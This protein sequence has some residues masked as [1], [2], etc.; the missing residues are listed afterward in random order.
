HEFQT[1]L[2]SIKA[3]ASALLSDPPPGEPARGELVSIVDEETDRL[4]RLVT[5]AIQMA[6]LEAGRIQL[7]C[8]NHSVA[9]LVQSAIRDAEGALAGRPVDLRL[10]SG[11]PPVHADFDLLGLAL[12]QV[13]GNALKF[14]PPGSPLAI[15]ARSLDGSVVV[16][17]TDHGPGIPDGEQQ[18]I[19]EKFYRGAAT[20]PQ[21]A[22]AGMGLAIA[23][24]ILRAHGGDI[25]VKSSPGHGAEFSLVIPVRGEDRR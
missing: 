11:L 1:P 22:G 13:L 18:R 17:V 7:R 4:S 9:A 12:R 24:E 25:C 20:K 5:D 3:A 10:A 23:R 14:S 19:F 21:V 6:R 16:T 2:T 8:E 15:E